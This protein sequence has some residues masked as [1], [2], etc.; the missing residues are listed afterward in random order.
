[1]KINLQSLHFKASTHLQ[2]FV[3]EK[4][5]RLTHI[6]DDIISAEV[7]LFS[8]DGKANG[9][10]YCEIH[11]NIPRQDDFVKKGADSYEAAITEAVDA[12]MEILKRKKES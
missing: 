8:E 9:N 7:T 6:Q 2:D 11:L 10:K 3:R 5:G 4:V 1:M 12:L